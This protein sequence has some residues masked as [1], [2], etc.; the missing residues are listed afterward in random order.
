MQQN[1]NEGVIPQ[2]F[3]WR[4]GI[5]APSSFSHIGD[6]GEAEARAFVNSFN[7]R[8]TYQPTE[9]RMSKQD[10]YNRDLMNFMSPIPSFGVPDTRPQ[11][12]GEL[13]AQ[14]HPQMI[15]S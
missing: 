10:Q 7:R 3:S 9:I 11:T 13:Q 8:P 5:N 14:L 6:P 15:F 4:A 1:L 12:Q 2:N